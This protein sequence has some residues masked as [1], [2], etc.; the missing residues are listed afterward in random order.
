MRRTTDI[1][2]RAFQLAE[3]CESLDEIRIKLKH[4]GFASVEA[5]L[6]GGRIRSDIAAILNRTAKPA[7]P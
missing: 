2:E 4:E 1:I 5:H 6:A 3:V 7:S